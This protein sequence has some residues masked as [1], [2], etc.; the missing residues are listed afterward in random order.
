[1]T[2]QAS[3]ET[4]T[5]GEQSIDK[6]ISVTSRS[7]NFH[8]LFHHTYLYTINICYIYSKEVLFE[9]PCLYLIRISPGL[10]W[11][12]ITRGGGGTKYPP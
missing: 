9:L 5:N 2:Q 7:S 11:G 8:Y 6:H 10:F 12:L 1:M 4:Y 3:I